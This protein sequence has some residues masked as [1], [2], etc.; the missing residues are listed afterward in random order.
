[1]EI[2]YGLAHSDIRGLKIS[3]QVLKVDLR[4][5]PLLEL[6]LDISII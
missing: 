1:M 3:A 4:V 5:E 6:V 2:Q